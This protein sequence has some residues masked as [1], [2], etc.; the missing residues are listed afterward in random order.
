MIRRDPVLPFSRLQNQ[1]VL[2]GG[3][4][5]LLPQ[6]WGHRPSLKTKDSMQARMWGLGV[7]WRPYH[8]VPPQGR[9]RVPE[10]PSISPK[11]LNSLPMNA[12]K[13]IPNPAKPII[14]P[15]YTKGKASEQRLSNFLE[16][17]QAPI[18]LPPSWAH[19]WAS[20]AIR[21]CLHVCFGW[22]HLQARGAG[23]DSLAKV[24]VFPIF[25][26]VDPGTGLQES[27]PQRHSLL[28]G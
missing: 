9:S 11:M 23:L 28:T 20:R 24:H 21:F 17:T 16:V 18:R 22:A 15:S 4:D 5:S 12:P 10:F 8:D 1:P 19:L 13:C 6:A 14:L 7:G 26:G 3:N 2:P 25:K 27:E